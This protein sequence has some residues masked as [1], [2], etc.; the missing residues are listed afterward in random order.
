MHKIADC[1][2]AR[3]ARIRLTEQCP[4]QIEQTTTNRLARRN[5]SASSVRS[6]TEICAASETIESGRPVSFRTVSVEM[7][8]SPGGARIRQHQFPKPSR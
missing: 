5:T 3:P 4:R 1:L 7:R 6:W 8:I 2:H